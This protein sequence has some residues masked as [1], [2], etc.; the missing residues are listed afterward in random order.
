MAVCGPALKCHHHKIQVEVDNFYD[1]GR[2][3][4]PDRY[5]RI[6]NGKMGFQVAPLLDGIFCH[7]LCDKNRL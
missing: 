4:H 1:D 7:V 3:A 6:L 5:T 2:A